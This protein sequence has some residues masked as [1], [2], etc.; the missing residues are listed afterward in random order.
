MLTAILRRFAIA[1][2]FVTVAYAS[3]RVCAWLRDEPGPDARAAGR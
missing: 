2:L 1:C 3:V